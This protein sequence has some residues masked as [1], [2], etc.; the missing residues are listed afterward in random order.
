MQQMA[1]VYTRVGE[2]KAALAFKGEV[3]VRVRP[4][5]PRPPMEVALGMLVS[6]WIFN[7][8]DMGT[9]VEGRPEERATGRDGA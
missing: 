7:A 2:M 3:E 9:R 1:H 4:H 5:Y 6:P 8:V